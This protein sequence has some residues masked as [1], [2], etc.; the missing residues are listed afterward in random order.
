VVRDVMTT[1][2][3]TIAPETRLSDA[4]E[5][6]HSHNIHHLPVVRDGLLVGMLSERHVRDATPS[7]LMLSDPAARRRSLYLTH[8]DQVC[9]KDP[10]TVSPG[11]S[12]VVAIAAMRRVRAGSLPVLDQGRL[13]GILTSGDLITLLERLLTEKKRS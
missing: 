1:N 6:M 7:I 12:L 10:V 3:A 4:V 2:P 11:D 13:V 5:L 8:V 9:I